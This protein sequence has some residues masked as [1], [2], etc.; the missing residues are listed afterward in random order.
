MS[1]KHESTANM[2]THLKWSHLVTESIRRL[3]VRSADHRL[4]LLST[5]SSITCIQ[6]TLHGNPQKLESIIWMCELSRC[7]VEFL[8]QQVGMSASWLQ[9][10]ANVNCCQYWAGCSMSLVLVFDCRTAFTYLLICWIFSVAQE[11]FWSLYN[12]GFV[13]T[14]SVQQLYC[15]H[16]QR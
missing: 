6:C 5:T 14:E 2:P 8:R 10:S 4:W 9:I 13:S 3:V 15:E 16:C 12:N 11:I 1:F 7:R